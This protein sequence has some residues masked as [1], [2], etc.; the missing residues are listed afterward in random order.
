MKKLV[1]ASFLLI[2]AAFILPANSILLFGGSMSYT[3]QNTAGGQPWSE[4]SVG[5]MLQS[6][7][8]VSDTLGIYSAATLGF[9]VGAQESGASL[10]IGSY[11]GI[12]L[13]ILLGVGYRM[14]ITPWLTAIGGAGMYLGSATLA[15]SN[16]S[17]SSF[18]AGGFGAGIGLSLLYSLSMNWGIGINV[19]A[20]YSFANPGDV[21]PTMAPNGIGLFGGI[22]VTYFSYPVLEVPTYS[23]FTA[24]TSTR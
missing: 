21:A 5:V 11:Q 20:A 15:A 22:G 7:F 4:T 19:N 24:A 8:D 3:N 18:Y 14:T 1:I 9:P 23:R 16:Q 17:L 12:G 6:Y 13:N 2:A 10:N